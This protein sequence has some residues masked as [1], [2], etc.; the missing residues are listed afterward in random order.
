[1]RIVLIGTQNPIDLCGYAPYIDI[2]EEAGVDIPDENMEYCQYSLPDLL[3]AKQ[4]GETN[5]VVFTEADPD[6]D[7]MTQTY[8]FLDT[9]DSG[10]VLVP[11][12]K[13]D[14]WAEDRVYNE[15]S[16]QNDTCGDAKDLKSKADFKKFWETGDVDSLQEACWSGEDQCPGFYVGVFKAEVSSIDHEIKEARK[17]EHLW[18]PADY[19]YDYGPDPFNNPVHQQHKVSSW[20][21]EESE[22]DHEDDDDYTLLAVQ[23]NKK[24]AE[25]LKI[26]EDMKGDKNDESD[27]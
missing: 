4:T 19:T 1:M 3:I 11:F 12:S 14:E 13:F 18:N 9:E 10:Q 2:G 7:D 16:Y 22:D 5:C 6:K 15:Q 23:S 27:K 8:I 25:L 24:L 20:G 26:V 21:D 17:A